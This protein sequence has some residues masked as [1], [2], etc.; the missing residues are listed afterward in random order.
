MGFENPLKACC[1]GNDA[2]YNANPN[3]WCGEII[4]CVENTRYIS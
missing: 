4:V 2:S 1:E 3:L